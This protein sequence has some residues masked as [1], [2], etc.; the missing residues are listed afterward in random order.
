MSYTNEELYQQ[1]KSNYLP[2]FKRFPLAFAKGKGSRLWDVEGKEY[3]DML[4]GIAVCN[5]GHS[6]PKV[7]A[8]VQKQ[9]AEL[10][11][12]SNF[13]V[14]LPQVE[15]SKKLKE[16]SGL[17]HVFITNSGAESVEGA[18][19]VARKF[20][21]KHGR[22][23]EIISMAKSF[24]GRTLGTIATG[25]AK[26][27]QG[28]EPIPTGFKQ[29]EFNNLPALKE[30]ISKDTAAIILEPVQGE[31]GINPVDK[32]YLKN[33][34][35]ICTE[36]GIAL[37]F[38]EVQCGIGRTGKWFAKD[39]YGIQPDIMTLAKGLGGGFPVG[40]FVCSSK[41]GDAIDYGDHGTTFGGNPLACASALATLSVIE[42]EN[43]LEEA[44]KKGEW[45]RGEFENMKAK[46]GEIKDIRGLGLMIGVEL[47]EPALPVVKLLLEKGIIAN[48]T[49]DKVLR[50]VP[51]LNIPMEDLKKVVEE[52]E[53]CLSETMIE[54]E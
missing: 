51:S 36:Q 48:A 18:M 10:M 14:T 3:I 21:H 39:H 25:Q 5:V 33:V 46:H 16:I 27:Q 12:I 53:K 49:A 2:T 29:V 54:H 1:D 11:H 9:A 20:A 6:H 22:G 7:V 4:A 24:H 23:G 44:T 50:L 43:L 15:L 32:S 26:Y 47:T 40:A 41:I 17:D 19:K 13:F 45:V 37:I 8:A 52:I 28:F 34:R 38:D 35:E 42:E 31:G 30:V